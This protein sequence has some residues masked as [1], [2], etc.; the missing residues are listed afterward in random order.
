MIYL[1]KGGVDLSRRKTQAEFEQEVAEVSFG[2]IEVLGKYERLT[3]P[4][5]I[6]YRDCGHQELKLPVKILIGHG[7][8]ECRYKRLSKTKTKTDIDL[9]DKMKKHGI[10][11]LEVLQPYKGVNQKILVRN[12]NCGHIYK[13]RPGNFIYR[14][15][16]CPICH[17]VKNTEIFK[18][19]LE[20]KYPGEY[21]VL[22]DYVGGLTPIEI[23][24][25]QCGRSW[26]CIP[27]DLLRDRR[28]PYCKMSKGELFIRDYL[29]A[30]GIQY[31]R[32]YTFSNCKDKQPL[33]FDFAVFVNDKIK[34]IEFDGEQHFKKS[35]LYASDILF[36]HDDIKNKFCEENNIP[37]LRIPYWVLRNKNK[38]TGMLDEFFS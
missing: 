32:Q 19:A 26:K 1:N 17:G 23:R 22:E 14:K 15:S 38:M 16:G 2:N 5:L 36:E 13:C 28:C 30:N 34:L 18:S 27:K 31:E 33:P 10:D 8:T 12:L 3:T 20:E 6:R 7:C 25:N 9:Q 24:H 4:I 35:N 21:T 37:L 29:E 11:Y